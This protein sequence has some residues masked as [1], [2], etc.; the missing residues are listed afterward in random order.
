VVALWQRVVDVARG[1][2]LVLAVTAALGDVD[3]GPLADPLQAQLA[4]DLRVD[5][6]GRNG[7]R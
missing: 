6:R 4:H 2:G 3:G 1:P 5:D 7:V